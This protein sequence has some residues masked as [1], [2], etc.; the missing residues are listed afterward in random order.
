MPFGVVRLLGVAV[1]FDCPEP[2]EILASF[3]GFA[4]F[5]ALA[6]SGSIV[7]PWLPESFMLSR[8]TEFCYID[9]PMRKSRCWF[10]THPAKTAYSPMTGYVVS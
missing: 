6:F 8:F 4:S 1:L 2:F 10:S 7:L 3:E 5:E 9:Q